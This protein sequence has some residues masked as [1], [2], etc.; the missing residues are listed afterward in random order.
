[1]IRLAR[2]APGWLLAALAAA[3]IALA[4]AALAIL[5]SRRAFRRA[6]GELIASGSP[7]LADALRRRHRRLY[8][9][10]G[11]VERFAARHGEAAVHLLGMPEIWVDRLA[12]HGRLADFR[13]VRRHAPQR[14]LF[15]C[16]LASLDHRR[17]APELVAWLR[18]GGEMLYMRRLALSGAG[19]SFDGRKALQV[20]RDNL[21]EIREMTGDPEW[22]SRYFAVK[23]L[24]HDPEARSQRAVWD[25]FGDAHPLVRRVAAT[26]V[27]TD[28]RVRLYEA[29][30]RLYLDDTV[31]EV[32]R[33][34]FRRIREELADLHRLEP[35]AL[36]ETQ[37]LHVLELLDLDSR[38]D[39]QLAMRY[40]AADNLELR[41]AAAS[42]LRHWNPTDAMT[43]ALTRAQREM[44]AVVVSSINRCHY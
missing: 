1:M 34:A 25:C 31:H 30:R 28:E 4:L 36:S 38:Q 12:R 3:S 43:A 29:L 16:F 21:P 13:R 32:R 10:S 7:P 5:L 22:P 35:A 24:V 20:F 41:H 26:E 42:F 19:E 6:L 23:L 17:L 2:A 8:R 37:A 9:L 11:L 14:G 33:A 44:I 15:S 39:E 27:A 18:S 40:L